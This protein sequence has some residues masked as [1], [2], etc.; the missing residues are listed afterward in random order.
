MGEACVL[1]PLSSPVVS[2][3]RIRSKMSNTGQSDTDSESTSRFEKNNMN[4]K[5]TLR[6]VSVPAPLEL[7]TG[8]GPRDS[9]HFRSKAL[10]SFVY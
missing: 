10:Y 5:Y 6:F 4:R 8:L 1:H 2:V 7:L 3:A 9:T